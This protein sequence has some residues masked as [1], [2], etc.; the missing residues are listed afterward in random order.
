[1]QELDTLE[2]S[3]AAGS[4]GTGMRHEDK[5]KDKDR[6]T[7]VPPLLF[8]IFFTF[9]HFLIFSPCVC[10]CMYVLVDG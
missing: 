7:N 5:D 9:A 2:S 4:I 3:A 8:A 10:L 1:M 6:P